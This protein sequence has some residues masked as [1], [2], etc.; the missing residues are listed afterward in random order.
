MND[1]LKT[2]KTHYEKALSSKYTTKEEIQRLY[3][4]FLR[5]LPS[6]QECPETLI[7]NDLWYK[8]ILVDTGVLSGIIDFETATQ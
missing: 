7:H 1:M 8:N 6:F 5:L 3:D 4:T 2:G